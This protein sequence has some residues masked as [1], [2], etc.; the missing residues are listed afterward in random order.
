MT[1]VESIHNDWQERKTYFKECNYR[2]K[3]DKDGYYEGVVADSVPSGKLNLA[4]K[5]K[6]ALMTDNSIKE[7]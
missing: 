4:E 3:Q 1:H 7:L 6:S 5:M 2:N